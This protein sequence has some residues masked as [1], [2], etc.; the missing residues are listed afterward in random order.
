M[1]GIRKMSPA[2]SQQQQT[3]QAMSLSQ[4]DA[5]SKALKAIPHSVNNMN[6]NIQS[7]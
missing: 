1:G 4:L 6:Y 3:C 2:I 5:N 7:C